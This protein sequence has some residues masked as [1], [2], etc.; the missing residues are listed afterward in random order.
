MTTTDDRADELLDMFAEDERRES[1][2]PPG[3]RSAKVTWANTIEPEP[4]RWAWEDAGQG[5][6]PA[7]SLSIAAGREGT[8]KSSQGIW[9]A[10]QTSRGTLEGCFAGKPRKVLYVAIED[11]WKYTLVPRAMA[12]KADLTM[13]GRFEVV[14]TTDDYNEASVILSLPHDNDLLKRTIIEHDVALV[15]IDPLLSVIGSSL[16]SHRSRDVREA[17]DPLAGIADETG[18]LIYGIAHFNKSTGTDA[19]ALITGAGAFKD[20]PR[21]IFGFARDEENQT[22]LMTQ[23][24]NSLGRDDLPSRTYTIESVEIPTKKGTAVTGRF[25]FTGET[26]RTVSDVLR[27]S[28]RDGSGQNMTADQFIATY[29]KGAG[30]TAPANTVIEAGEDAG[31]SESTLKNARSKVADTKST[32]FKEKTHYWILREDQPKTS[33]DTAVGTVGTTFK[34]VV[35]TVPT[36]VP[37]ESDS[38]PVEAEES[39]PPGA[40]TAS[41]PGQ[42]D[43]VAAALAN[44]KKTVEALQ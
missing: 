22:R 28:R 3:V 19:A 38:D 10:S 7:G 23:V 26:T 4:V 11:S 31:F 9:M 40:V 32:G 30:G 1:M 14:T 33:V 20:V 34:Q 16:D 35:P 21:T 18:A 12:A 36:S 27:D 5:R 29:L 8:G 41:T 13:I 42:T 17:L 37:T 39:V 6:I 24:K 2:P 43:R 25:L 15:V 44:A